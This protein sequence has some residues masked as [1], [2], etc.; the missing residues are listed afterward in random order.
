MSSFDRRTFLIS[1]AA[2]TGCGFTPVYGPGGTG[3]ALRGK[4]E[5]KAPTDRYSY[6]LSNRLIDQFG[7]VETPLYRLNYTINTSKE[8]IGITRDQDI[9]R[10]HITGRVSYILSDLSS[11]RVLAKDTVKSFTAYSAT[12]S[13]V[14]TLSASRAAYDRLMVILADQMVSQILATATPS[15]AE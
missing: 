6:A 8:P 15:P 1:L 5:I 4:V 14:D 10:Y 9:T 2:L 7:P 13:S 12:G 11:G 3:A